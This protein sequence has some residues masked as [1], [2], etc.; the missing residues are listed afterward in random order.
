M[1]CE[2]ARLL[3]PLELNGADVSGVAL[4]GV[5]KVC[6]HND[7]VLL[8]KDDGGR[9]HCDELAGVGGSVSV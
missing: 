8:A 3:E 2:A 9:V 7:V 5:D 4:A 1:D 6:V